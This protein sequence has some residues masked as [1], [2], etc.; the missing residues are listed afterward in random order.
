VL[1]ITS[2]NVNGIR[3][4]HRKGLLGWLFLI[5]PDIF[6]IQETR[7]DPDSLPAEL[8]APS[9]YTTFWEQSTRKGYSGVALFCRQTPKTVEA[10]K[11]DGAQHGESGRALKADFDKFVLVNVYV[12]SRENTRTWAQKQAFLQNLLAYVREIAVHAKP[13]ILCGD[14]NIAHQQHLDIQPPASRKRHVSLLNAETAW[15]NDLMAYGL[16]DSFRWRNA[17]VEAYTWK[18]PRPTWRL[19]YIF[20]SKALCMTIRDAKVHSEAMFSDHCPVS[21]VLDV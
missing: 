10:V 20:V 6:C 8:G 13:I 15:V 1:T 5:K 17:D 16:V 3:A 11:I 9:G 12:P 19:D 7:C 18:Q 14:F 21:V 2:C 4:A